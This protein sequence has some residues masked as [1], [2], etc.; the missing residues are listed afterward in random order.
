MEN[1]TPDKIA[2]IKAV[3]KEMETSASNHSLIQ[4]NKYLFPYKEKIYRVRMPNQNEQ[5][6]AEQEQNKVKLTREG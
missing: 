2:Q 1:L 6:L 5:T 4:D 3:L